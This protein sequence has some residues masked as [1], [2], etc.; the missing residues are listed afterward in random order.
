[1][2]KSE[3]ILGC[4]FIPVHSVVLPI[5]LVIILTLF[6]LDLTSPYQMLLYYTA[7]FVLILA[8]MF[9]YLRASFSDMIDEFWRAIRA[10]IMG[11]LLFRILLWV[12]GFLLTSIMSSSNPNQDVI[13]TD[14]ASNFRVMAVVTCILA[15]IVEEAMFRG[16]LFGTIRQKNRIVAYIVSTLLFCLFHLWSNLV[17]DFS[18]TMVLYLIQYVP[19]SIALAW[20]YERGGTIWSPILLHAS[21]NLIATLQSR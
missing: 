3:R 14:I 10:V 15:P 13:T 18:W 1:M 11:Y 12:A 5:L 7:S 4:I 16:A 8:V 2:Q 19:A 17:F 9:R 6:D 21:I 20:C